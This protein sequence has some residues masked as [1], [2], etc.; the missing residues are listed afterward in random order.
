MAEETAVLLFGDSIA[1]GFGLPVEDG[2]AAQL[3]AALRQEGFNV[4]MLGAGVSGDTTAGGRARLDWALTPEVQIIVIVLG[5]NDALRAISP[6]ETRDNLTHLIAAA[7]AKGLKIVLT[8]MRAPPNLGAEYAAEFEPI[9]AEL[10]ELHQVTLYPFI[11]E[12]V[13][14]DPALNQTDGIHPNA[15]GVKVIVA[16]LIPLVANL[17]EDKS[18][19]E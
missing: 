13:A 15:E 17:I 16:G 19:T 12:G 1:A 8:G 3:Q 2:L 10:A 6:Q 5:G 18:E 4:T 11:L 7:K 14:A 9:Y